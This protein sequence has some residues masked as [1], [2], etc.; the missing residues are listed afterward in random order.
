M[1]PP[2]HRHFI[3]DYPATTLFLVIQAFIVLLLILSEITH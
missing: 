3:R 2:E 1:N